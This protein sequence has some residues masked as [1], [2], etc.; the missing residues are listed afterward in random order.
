MKISMWDSVRRRL[1]FTSAYWRGEWQ[2]Q[3]HGEGRAYHVLGGT[4]LSHA[5]NLEGR[6]FVY[7][8]GG[9][10]G[11]SRDSIF[12]ARH[13]ELLRELEGEDVTV[14]RDGARYFMLMHY[15]HAATVKAALSL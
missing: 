12:H 7:P 10:I 14:M 15:G 1:T 6:W 2:T 9:S 8:V 4:G 13:Y 5:F 3:S 11:S